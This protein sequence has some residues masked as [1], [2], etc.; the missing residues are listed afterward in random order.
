MRP[1]LIQL[2]FSAA[3]FSSVYFNSL[4]IHLQLCNICCFNL[5][6]FTLTS[7]PKSRISPLTKRSFYKLFTIRFYLPSRFPPVI[8]HK[9]F[10]FAT[11][12][13]RLRSA[14]ARLLRLRFKFVPNEIPRSPTHKPP[15]LCSV[16]MP[17]N[18]PKRVVC[19]PH[20][21]HK[22]KEQQKNHAKCTR[23]T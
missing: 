11:N 22:R 7:L 8:F 13:P 19:A 16:Y 10:R 18:T 9:H 4:S 2:S 1:N 15:P 12:K 5:H 3:L 14:P 20:T 23:S 21:S 6:I 17:I